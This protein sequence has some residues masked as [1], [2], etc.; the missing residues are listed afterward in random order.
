MRLQ[1]GNKLTSHLREYFPG[2]LAAVNVRR[3]GVAHRIARVL[4]AAAPTPEQAAKLTLP[5]LRALLKK[6]GRKN[7]I[8]AEAKR[9]QIA[10]RE[11]QMRRVHW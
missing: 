8:D 7:T 10:L 3:E 9:L 2:F 11:S 5:Q 4:L 6:A 1:A